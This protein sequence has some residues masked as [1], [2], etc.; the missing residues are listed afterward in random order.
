MKFNK[1][2]TFVQTKWNTTINWSVE[3][4]NMMLLTKWDIIFNGDCKTDQTVKWIFYAGGML[5]R[6]WVNKNKAIT[7]D[8]RCSNG[9]LHIQW[10]LIWNN[11]ERLMKNSRSNLNDWFNSTD[12]RWIVMDG[13]SVL[14][15]YSP[16]VFTN[17]TMPPGAE[18]FVAALSIYK[19]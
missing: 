11:F 7:N 14:I 9:W 13:A 6:R 12:K 1:A 15:E 19:D 4:L 10:V 3:W 18:D 16:S 2:V 17:S 5:K 8:F